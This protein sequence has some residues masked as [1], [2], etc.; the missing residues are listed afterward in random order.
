MNLWKNIEY[1]RQRTI[2]LSK[3]FFTKIRTDISNGPKLLEL[4]M[5]TYDFQEVSDPVPD[6]DPDF[7]LGTKKTN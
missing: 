5:P 3:R 1:E 7:T 6:L 4:S 2:K